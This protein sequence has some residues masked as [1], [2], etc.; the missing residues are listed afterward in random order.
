MS[1]TETTQAG[2]G[3]VEQFKQNA[4]QRRQ[5]AAER[6]RELL[7]RSDEARAGDAAALVECMAVLGRGEEDLEG[8]IEL[9][10]R[11]AAIAQAEEQVQAL[12]AP[13][14]EARAEQRRVAAWADAQRSEL[15]AKIRERAAAAGKALGSAQAAHTAAA[16]V[17][18]EGQEA[19]DLWESIVA[20]QPLAEIRAA[21]RPQKAIPARRQTREEII[22]ARRHETVALRLHP[23]DRTR[24]GVVESVNA[25]LA[26]AGHQP[27]SAEE[28]EQYGV[29]GWL[30]DA[31]NRRRTAKELEAQKG[32]AQV[33]HA[34]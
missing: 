27:F 17:A 28:I 11:I 20:G 9:V 1:K 2:V 14:K 12:L 6:Y 31:N 16:G 5:A 33:A 8:D 22:E 7:M 24:D 26:A 29:R 4:A 34:E 21:R 32:D 10:R 13:L 18:S 3:L 15:E 19:R 23:I 30:A 25:A